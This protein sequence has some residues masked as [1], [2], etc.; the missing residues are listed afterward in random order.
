MAGVFTMSTATILLRTQAAPRWIALLGI[1]VAL[2]LLI[3]L[4]LSSWLYLLFP[5][6]IGLLSVYLL[7]RS[8]T[9]SPGM[10]PASQIRSRG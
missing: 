5:S 2:V 9:E 8:F 1:A 10:N 6:W 3:T 4:G 7:W